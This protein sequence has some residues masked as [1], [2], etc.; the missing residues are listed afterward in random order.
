MFE[1]FPSDVALSH[2]VHEADWILASLERWGSSGVRL[3][4][5][6]PEGFDAYV[7]VFHPLLF[8]THD[9]D[10]LQRSW[11][12]VGAEHGVSL[13]LNVSLWEVLGLDPEEMEREYARP[14]VIRRTASSPSR[15]AKASGP[16]SDRTRDPRTIA[17]S[18]CG[19]GWASCFPVHP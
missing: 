15:S 5:S 17:G 7:R 12:E 11:T 4:S 13:S 19:R 16:C 1:V 14:A 18:A 2:D 10:D 8:G 3:G 9:S 6:L